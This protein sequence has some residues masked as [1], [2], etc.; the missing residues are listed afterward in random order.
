MGTP[1]SHERTLL[2]LL[3]SFGVS[4]VAASHGMRHWVEHGGALVAARAVR[5]AS[6]VEQAPAPRGIRPPWREPLVPE[7]RRRKGRPQRKMTADAGWST[8][9]SFSIQSTPSHSASAHGRSAT[10]R[11]S[12]QTLRMW[13]TPA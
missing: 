13:L 4:L 5:P 9:R 1:R 7:M 10:S 2:A 8:V 12:R 11:P 6:A 3:A